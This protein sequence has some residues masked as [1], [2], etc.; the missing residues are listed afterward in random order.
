MTNQVKIGFL[1]SMLMAASFSLNAEDLPA[2][3]EEVPPPPVVSAL[4]AQSD[5][6]SVTLT[7]EP[8]DGFGGTSVILRSDRPITATNYRSVQKI[9]ELP[10][11]VTTYQDTPETP[12]DLYYAVLSVDENGT[13]YDFFLPTN[14]SLLV[15]VLVESEPT[16]ISVSISG[17][18]TIT[19]NDAVIATWNSSRSEKNL[20]IYRSTRP[21]TG[22]DSLLSAI[23]VATVPDDGTPFVDYPVPGVPCYYAV[24]DESS[25]R[26]GTTSFVPGEN[27]SRLPVEISTRFSRV[28]R[29][30]IPP[31]RSMPLPWLNPRN[32]PRIQPYT[33]SKKTERMIGRIVSTSHTPAEIER[34]PYVFS[35]DLQNG[36]GGES[37]ALRNI[38]EETFF[39]GN[40]EAAID[41]LQK[42]LAI[43]RTPETA[44]RARFYIGEAR[45]FSGNYADALLEFLLAQD[46]Y[47]NQ[48]REWIQY[49]LE[50]LVR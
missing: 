36:S 22:T 18:D 19:R 26:S 10:H 1:A 33:F 7:W 20:V 49:T 42:F 28:Q 39:P 2:I 3:D 46:R 9:A 5:G 25:I 14:N 13:P 43:R 50:K 17:F 35:M 38:L 16:D 48:S 21:F 41:K 31:L 34:V 23:V 24:L 8:V 40:W 37:L 29:S 4:S 6:E 15:P 44:A 11:S 45:Y 47:Y 27:T 12:G 32:Q 30:V